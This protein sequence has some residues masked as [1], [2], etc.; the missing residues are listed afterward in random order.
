MFPQQLVKEILVQTDPK[1]RRGKW[2]VAMLEYDL[3]IKPINPIKGQGLAEL[4]AE[5]NFHTVDINLIVALSEE[6]EEEDSYLQV[7]DMF[8]SSPWYSNI[9]YV[10]QYVNPPLKVPKGKTRS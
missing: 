8:I 1:G 3:E 2:I 9:V 10:L 4:M 6:E 5:S 7:S